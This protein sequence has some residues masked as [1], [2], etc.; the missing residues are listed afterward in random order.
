[1][2]AQ[3]ARL[4]ARS[5]PLVVLILALLAALTGGVSLAPKARAAGTG[6]WHTGGQ[7]IL[8]ADGTPVRSPASTGSASRPRTTRRTGC[9]PRTTRTCS[10]RSRRLGFNTIRLPFSNQLFDAGST[11]ER[12]RLLRKNPDLQGLTGAADHG[13]DRRLRRADRPAGHPGPPP[14]RR[15][16]PVALWY[17][18]AYPESRWIADWTM[19]A[20]HYAGNPTVIGADLHNEPHGPAC[21]GCGDR[22]TD[23]R[24]AAERAGNAILGVEPELA[25]H[26]RGRRDVQRRRRTGGAATCRAPAQSRCGSTSPNRLVYSAHDYPASVYP[27]PWFSDPSYPDN[28][29]GLGRELGLPVQAEHRAGPA[30]RVRHDA[31]RPDQRPAVAHGRLIGTTCGTGDGADQ[32]DVLV[33]EPELRR[34]RRHPQGRLDDRQ[35]RQGGLPRVHQ[36]H[37]LR[38]GRRRLGRWWRRRAGPS[39][40]W[41]APPPTMWTTTG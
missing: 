28:L 25:D 21:W 7:Q 13:Q 30:G 20:Q 31:G 16:R 36:V 1:M 41:P 40:A 37:G 26:R 38:P 33:V 14:A 3:G 22:A 6:Y 29:P 18:G 19:L 9:G 27:Q 5:V 17:T 12:H 35:P 24:L 32:L 23:W 11:P 34:H 8:D 10:T 39:A 15:R 2:L 4:K